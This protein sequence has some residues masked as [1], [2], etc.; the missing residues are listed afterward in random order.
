MPGT[1]LS[2]AISPTVTPHV[3]A[4]PTE[5]PSI[6]NLALWLDSGEGTYLDIEGTLPADTNNAR[7]GHWRDALT[8]VGWWL[9]VDGSSDYR[10][11]LLTAFGGLRSLWFGLDPSNGMEAQW[12]WSEDFSTGETEFSFA[13]VMMLGS[14]TAYNRQIF[15]NNLR[16]W[17]RYTP[18]ETLELVV[19]NGLPSAKTLSCS[20]SPGTNT[21]FIVSGRVSSSLGYALAIDGEIMAT[22]TGTP[23]SGWGG[24]VL[25]QQ[26]NPANIYIA[27]FLVWATDLTNT[28]LSQAYQ[29]LANKHGL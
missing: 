18:S 26:T 15:S 2:L 23:A 24:C 13:I 11:T 21:P 12:L 27:E 1:S 7:V 3:A 16:A 19:D 25:G 9:A 22:D 17:L 20:L 29:Y 6:S 4:A 8:G 5:P 10:P 14:D 28:E